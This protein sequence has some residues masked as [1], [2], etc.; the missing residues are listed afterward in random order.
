MRY[1][2]ARHPAYTLIMILFILL[3]IGSGV[4]AMLTFGIVGKI[5]L[6]IVDIFFIAMIVWIYFSTYYELR[7]EGL[8]IHSGPFSEL[9]VYENIV[10]LTKTRGY[11]FMCTL[12]FN[13]V[14]IDY[15]MNGVKSKAYVS[16]LKEDEFLAEL[17]K[18]RM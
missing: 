1:E 14:E 8:Y 13:R 7:D 5:I 6:G 2:S 15:K 10:K 9:I 4:G 12:D 3:L 18:K 16:P 11:S 17:D